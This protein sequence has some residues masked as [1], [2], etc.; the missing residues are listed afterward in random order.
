VWTGLNRFVASQQIDPYT[1]G[2]HDGYAQDAM[3][4]RGS[5]QEWLH[6]RAPELG[7]ALTLAQ[8]RWEQGHPKSESER[9]WRLVGA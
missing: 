1:G 8:M 2:N 3:Y 9:G 4:A 6:S 5:A 7:P